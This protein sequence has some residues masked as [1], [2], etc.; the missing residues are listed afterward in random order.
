MK[1][2]L[3]RPYLRLREFS[4][5]MRESKAMKLGSRKAGVRAWIGVMSTYVCESKLT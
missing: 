3:M 5:A 2:N 4:G 1:S